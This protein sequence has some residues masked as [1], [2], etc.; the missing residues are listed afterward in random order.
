MVYLFVFSDTQK[1]LR[2]RLSSREKKKT[3]IELYQIFGPRPNTANTLLDCC[4]LSCFPVYCSAWTAWRSVWRWTAT[5]PSCWSS[6]Q[7]QCPYRSNTPPVFDGMHFRQRKIRGTFRP[8]RHRS[9]ARSNKPA[10]GQ[11]TI[12]LQLKYNICGSNG[13]VNGLYNIE[14][15]RH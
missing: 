6:P 14:L 4:V 2:F 10:G 5:T 12:Y 15:A 9:S 7:N 8:A 3:R 11:E 1:C 13:G